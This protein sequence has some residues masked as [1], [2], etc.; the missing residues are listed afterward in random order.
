MTTAKLSEFACHDHSKH[1]RHIPHNTQDNLAGTSVSTSQ[2]SIDRPH[3]DG[4]GSQALPPRQRELAPRLRAVVERMAVPKS[5]REKQQYRASRLAAAEQLQQAKKE[6]ARRRRH[7]A[8]RKV[9]SQHTL[10]AAAKRGGYTSETLAKNGIKKE[11]YGVNKKLSGVNKELYGRNKGLSGEM[12]DLSGIK[13][14]LSGSAQQQQQRSVLVNRIQE[15]AMRDRWTTTMRQAQQVKKVRKL[16][17][18]RKAEAQEQA[19]ARYREVL[20]ERRR[21]RQAT[22]KSRQVEQEIMKSG[23]QDKMKSNVTENVAHNVRK[24]KKYAKSTIAK[25][26]SVR[27]KQTRLKSVNGLIQNTRNQAL[28]GKD[29]VNGEVSSNHGG[30]GKVKPVG[31]G[32]VGGKKLIKLNMRT[33]SA[34]STQKGSISTSN[35]EERKNNTTIDDTNPPK[36][37]SVP[38]A[39]ATQRESSL[40]SQRKEEGKDTKLAEISVDASI[41]QAVADGGVDASM[42]SQNGTLPDEVLA[43]DASSCDVTSEQAIG[44]VVVPDKPTTDGGA[45]PDDL[46]AGAPAGGGGVAAATTSGVSDARVVA[47]GAADGTDCISEVRVPSDEQAIASGE[48]M[49]STAPGGV[50]AAVSTSGVSDTPVVPPAGESDG[51]DRIGEVKVSSDKQA[52]ASGEG[53][54]T[55]AEEPSMNETDS[56]SGPSQGKSTDLS[57]VQLSEPSHHAEGA[58]AELSTSTT[59]AESNGDSQ[60]SKSA[61]GV[62]TEATGVDVGNRSSAPDMTESVIVA[63]GEKAAISLQEERAAEDDDSKL[64]SLAVKM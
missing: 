31:K 49:Q 3:A 1:A 29:E 10:G 21:R 40:T 6:N 27:A 42:E 56:A 46:S 37:E 38:T 52:I 58:N 17:A 59:Q 28:V 48:G 54:H 36:R 4:K 16:E 13:Q 61:A 62:R 25:S 33:S 19:H 60:K 12:K 14:D 43:T 5:R 45:S 35:D 7:A 23:R 50:P 15:V 51:T 39:K 26:T 63:S 22:N 57:H 24:K 30:F 11:L 9:V 55:A 32:S 53:M 64:T 47:A 18:K 8:L 2:P 44:S 34:K 20:L 41:A